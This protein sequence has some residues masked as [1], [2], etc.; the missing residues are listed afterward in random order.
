MARSVRAEVPR[1]ETW[2]LT[3]L[4]SSPADWEQ[5]F[6][7]LQQDLVGV[8]QYHGKLGESAAQL[9]AC[10]EAEEAYL[11]RVQRLTSYASL[12]LS[13]DGTSQE[14]QAAATRIGGLQA[15]IGAEISFIRSEI[16]ALPEGTIERYLSEDPRLG[17]FRRN[18]QRLADERPHMLH[19]EAESALAAIGELFSSPYVT[20]NRAKSSD[21]QFQRFVDGDGQERQNSFALYEDEFEMSANPKTR[22]N[23]FSSFVD[24]LR[25]Y[26]NTFAATFATEI[27]K[28]VAMSRV[29]HYESATHMLL[30]PQEIPLSSYH[31]QL[32]IIQEELSPHMQR[33]ARLRKRVLGLDELLYCDLK[34]PLDPDFVPK[35]SI[36]EASDIIV[37]AL[38]VL[39]D[40][41]A[42]IMRTGL[43][44]RWVD[45]ADNVGKST[46]AFCN[47]VYGVHPYI[48]ITWTNTMRSMFVLAHELGHAGHG[49][50]AGRSQR[51]ANTRSSMYFVEAPSTCNE[52]L[53]GNHLLRT[54][55]DVRMRRWVIMQMLGTY[56]HNFITHLLEGELQRRLYAI[57]ESGRAITSQTLSHEKGEI[58][59]RFW[60]DT[61][62]VD[63]GAEL[64]WMRQPHYYMGLYPYTYSAGL[65]ISTSAAAA[66]EREGQPAVDR[67]LSALR[68]GGT[69]KPMDLIRLTGVDMTTPAPIHE[70]VA[71]VGRLVDELEKSFA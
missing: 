49:V 69:L 40:E 46:G 58:L 3:D 12:N 41:Y 9:F 38:S 24:G 27:R 44:S 32:D 60:G 45:L 36:E 71:S 20:Y 22:R 19:A 52:L 48:L 4:F 30:Q 63:E 35:I 2:D 39:G 34:A 15:R 68:A 47:T 13:S 33:Y 56:H 25:P 14:N 8:T 6:T 26:R 5:E 65:T 64:T 42:E 37:S 66:I 54:T 43:S 59:R 10:L 57:A 62:K 70:A 11:T 53:L 55:E 50:M 21:M 61:L 23:A 17:D 28:N 31:A 51:R 7:A 29:R 16:L 18:L 67:W 1:A